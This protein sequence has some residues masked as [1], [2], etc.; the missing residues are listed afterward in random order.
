MVSVAS[1][2]IQNSCSFGRYIV[3]MLAPAE[4]TGNGNIKISK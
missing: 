2:E 3:D 1:N 4:V